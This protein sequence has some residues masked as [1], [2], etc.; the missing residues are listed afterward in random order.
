MAGFSTFPAGWPILELFGF[1]GFRPGPPFASPPPGDVTIHERIV[2]MGLTSE[3]ITTEKPN[4]LARYLAEKGLDLPPDSSSILNWYVGKKYSLVVSYISDLGQF[5]ARPKEETDGGRFLFRRGQRD[6]R[7]DEKLERRSV[8]LGLFI[9]FPTDTM[10]FP[11][12]PTSVYGS[13]VIPITVFVVG[14]ATPTV[15]SAISRGSTTS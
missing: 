13:Q 4:A 12:K 3:V 15:F 5:R 8:P 6:P 2:K 10:Y 7:A 11:L 14:F 1:L 9:D